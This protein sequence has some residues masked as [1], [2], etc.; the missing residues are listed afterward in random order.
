MGEGGVGLTGSGSQVVGNKAGR[1]L[2]AVV[3]GSG[4]DIEADLVAFLP[5]HHLVVLEDRLG[6]RHDGADFGYPALDVQFRSIQLLLVAA[7]CQKEGSG[8]EE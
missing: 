8:K 1:I 7:Y 4:V 2:R 6:L 3:L 5:F